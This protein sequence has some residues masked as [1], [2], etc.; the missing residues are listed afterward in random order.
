VQQQLPPRSTTLLKTYSD[1]LALASDHPGLE[2]LV[3]FALVGLGGPSTVFRQLVP[4]FNI[5]KTY[6]GLRLTYGYTPLGLDGEPIV[7]K[8]LANTGFHLALS[9]GAVA[10]IG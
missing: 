7:Q 10:G 4:N 3:V 9:G 5:S 6:A 8:A 1:A 2:H